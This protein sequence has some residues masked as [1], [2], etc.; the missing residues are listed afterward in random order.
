MRII[1]L[2]EPSA[3]GTFPFPAGPERYQRLAHELSRYAGTQV[4]II[5][6]VLRKAPADAYVLFAGRGD[7]S[8]SLADCG[9]A[10]AA[11]LAPSIVLLDV[12]WQKALEQLERHRLAGGVDSLRL[13]EWLARPSSCTGPFGLRYLTK[14]LA[15]SCVPMP[16]F[17]S[18]HYCLLQSEYHRG[19]PHLLADYLAAY[20]RDQKPLSAV[21]V[22]SLA[23]LLRALTEEPGGNE[24][25]RAGIQGRAAPT[26]QVESV[27]IKRVI[28]SLKRARES[29]HMTLVQ[30][31]ERS[32][33]DPEQLGLLEGSDYLRATLGTLR[34]YLIALEPT[35]GW[36]LA[37]TGERAFPRL[38]RAQER[39]ETVMTNAQPIIVPGIGAEV[40]V[41]DLSETSAIPTEMPCVLVE[42][43]MTVLGN[44]RS[45]R[46]QPEGELD[47][48]TVG[49][50]KEDSYAGV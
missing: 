50:H 43:G 45:R 49:M 27:S 2:L 12:S 22:V 18:A 46:R 8:R 29:A 24:Q 21:P 41:A 35:W 9:P 33:L 4:Q 19:M 37:E 6:D 11:Q 23:R 3:D 10:L 13:S 34:A 44:R 30:V 47:N 32:G 28:D 31:A 14:P 25:T 40:K 5:K 17:R 15:A 39:V 38:Q 7:L 20:D 48:P 16:S 42:G 1:L 36:T 26:S